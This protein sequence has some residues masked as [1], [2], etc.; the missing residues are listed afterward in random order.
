MEMYFVLRVKEELSVG[1]KGRTPDIIFFTRNI[2][3]ML[4]K[5]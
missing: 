5:C 4:K 1:R 2:S 3:G